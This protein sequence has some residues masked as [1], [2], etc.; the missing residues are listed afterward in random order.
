MPRHDAITPMT[1]GNMR[2]NGV[3]S[4]LVYCSVCPHTV[5][6]NVDAYAEALV[7][8]VGPRMVSTGCGMI[9]ADARP[10]WRESYDPGA[11]T[12]SVA[13]QRSRGLFALLEILI[14]FL[15][16]RFAN[17]PVQLVGEACKNPALAGLHARAQLLS[18]KITDAPAG[19]W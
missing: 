5:V 18:I 13:A 11:A 16:A 3:R 10:N 8:A 12:E 19:R 9:D 2:S 1:F 14:H 6:F 15:A 17:L 7:P 4:L